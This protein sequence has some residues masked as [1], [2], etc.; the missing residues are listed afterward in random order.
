MFHRPM[1]Y[2]TSAVVRFG[3]T[4]NCL[5]L[6][7]VVFPYQNAMPT[8]GI[9]QRDTFCAADGIRTTDA[10]A[11]QIT[12]DRQGQTWIDHVFC[13]TGTTRELYTFAGLE[14]Y[15]VELCVVRHDQHGRLLRY[16]TVGDVASGEARRHSHD[17][18]H[19]VL[20]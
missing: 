19:E 9:T 13:R 5:T 3:R 14:C 2:G 18:C 11:L 20:A 1:A 15:Y 4:G 7:T 12:I 16:D 10:F 6:H 17:G 8:I